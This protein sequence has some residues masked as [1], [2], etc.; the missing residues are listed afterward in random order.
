MDSRIRSE[1]LAHSGVMVH[2][3]P[4]LRSFTD[5]QDEVL[6][7]SGDAASLLRALD[8]AFPG[9][10]ERILDE[11][12]RPRPYVN[13]FVNDEL[14]RGPLEQVALSRGDAVHILPSVAGGSLA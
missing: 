7:E 11:M 5:G 9:I 10:R 6:L 1:E 13:V 12:G 3:P 2:I 4:A 8:A 14:V